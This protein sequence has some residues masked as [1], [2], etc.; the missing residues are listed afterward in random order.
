MQDL[1]DSS[2]QAAEVICRLPWIEQIKHLPPK[3]AL[4]AVNNRKA[5]YHP[6]NPKGQGWQLAGLDREQ[7]PLLNGRLRAVGLLLGSLSGGIVAIDHDGHSA[8]AKIEELSGL[9]VDEALPMTVGFTSQ[10]DG[11]YQVLYKVPEALWETIKKKSYPTGFKILGK[12]GKEKEEALE[13]RWNGHQSVILGAHPDTSGY[14]WLPGRSPWEVPVADAP[15]WIYM[16]MRDETPDHVFAPRKEWQIERPLETPIPLANLITKKHQGYVAQGVSEG[17]RNEAGAAIARDLIGA[18]QWAIQS[19]VYFDGNAESLFWQFAQ[20]SGISEKESNTIW[21]SAQKGSPTPACSDEILAKAV[22][23]WERKNKPM[24]TSNRNGSDPKAAPVFELLEPIADDKIQTLENEFEKIKSKY[25]AALERV[26]TLTQELEDADNEDK[27]QIASRLKN[28]KDILKS[29]NSTRFNARVELK[30]LTQK[31]KGEAETGFAKDFVVIQEKVAERLSYNILEKSIYIDDEPTKFNSACLWLY[32]KTG[33]LNWNKGDNT[34]SLVILDFAKKN[35]FCPVK[36]Y[37]ESIEAKVSHSF[38]NQCVPYLFGIREDEPAYPLAV[39]TFKAQ[40]VGSVRRI[41]EP[42]CHHRLMPILHGQQKK[43]KSTFLRMLYNGFSKAGMLP[44]ADKD[45][46]QMIQGVWA[47]EVDE[48]DKLFRTREASSLKSFVALTE[49]YFR[50]PYERDTLSYPR[51]SVMWGTTNHQALFSDPTGNTRYPVI[52]IPEGW[53]I[54]T[55]WV[56]ENRDNIWAAALDAYWAGVQNEIPAD[57][58]AAIA[59][60]AENY[61]D[62]DA[63][64]EPV[65]EILAKAA[66]GDSFSLMEIGAL[67]KFGNNDFRKPEQNRVTAILRS[68]GWTNKVV[69]YANKNARRWVKDSP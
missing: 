62:R 29:L 24:V 52:S 36:R 48:C 34:L 14:Q 61:I 60:D 11:R 19:G 49:D 53:A 67:L 45:G 35:E 41:Y 22:K 6:D 39:A 10:R 13:L 23:S 51:R 54:P 31:Q 18:E 33:H 17:G 21:R 44:M 56:K 42:G 27:R 4:C 20:K 2:V 37:L 5:P 9:T 57:L 16:A 12:D 47:F 50:A 1:H 58:E 64:H 8:D 46:S 38:L 59:E 63:L 43:G 26:E 65:E 7:F 32:E 3:W 69:L 30:Q 55:Q 15:D 28:A 40:L 68:L 25:E 66:F